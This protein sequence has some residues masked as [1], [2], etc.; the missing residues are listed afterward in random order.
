MREHTSKL[1]GSPGAWICI[2]AC[3]CAAGVAGAGV[4]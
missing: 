4:V 2:C 1:S 3:A